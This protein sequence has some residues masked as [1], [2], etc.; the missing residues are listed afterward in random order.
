MLLDKLIF[1]AAHY[2]ALAFFVLTCWGFGRVALSGTLRAHPIDA[3]MGHALSTTIGMGIWICAL[4][5]LGILGAMRA[6]WIF[7]LLAA[8]GILAAA[9]ILA[10][11]RAL[12]L[13]TLPSWRALAF[14]RG[15]AGA[16]VVLV[17]CFVLFSPLKPPHEW[18]ELAY[19]LPHAQQWAQSGKLQVNEWLRYPWFPF[20]Y[21]LLYAA[22]LVVYDDM[23]PHM[24]HA[25]AGWIVALM[26]FRLGMRYTSPFEACLASIIWLRMSRA[27]FS[28]AYIDMGVTLF[29]LGACIAIQLWLEHP[30]ERRWL[31]AAAFMM[32]LAVGSKYQALTFLPLFGV[33]VLW[34]DRRASTIAMATV[35][36]AIPCIYWYVRNALL[37]GDPFNPLG[38]KIFGFTDW[39]LADYE[40]QF[41]DIRRVY[42]WPNGIFWVA[43]LAPL[44]PSL[45]K[46]K[47]LP[48]A[49]I[50]CS[51]AT[52]VW[53]VT[54]HYP[55]Y[56]MPAY[57]LLALLAACVWWR[58][59]QTA[60]Q[61]IGGGTW[62]RL[63][64]DVRNRVQGIGWALVLSG[65]ALAC[66]LGLSRKW[67]DVSATPEARQAYLQKNA[68]STYGDLLEY[69]RLNPMGKIYQS[70]LEGALYY[71]PQPIWGDAFGPWRS[72]D[73]MHLEPDALAAKLTSMNFDALVLHTP[74]YPNL[75]SH[76]HFK[77]Y[78]VEVHNTT[79]YK[80]FRIAG[81]P[82]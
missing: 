68:L 69:L 58:P 53:A 28:N 37:T 13:F 6:Q 9:Q 17:A 40:Y 59:L 52:L 72:R 19:H 49:M 36:L 54:S 82:Q 77:Q 60:L 67:S 23:F 38:G 74:S 41:A 26:V 73:F 3:W 76:Q 22:S 57:P 51:Y 81:H 34:R 29:V 14:S 27:D 78:F 35:F 66:V 30:Q 80:V 62:H 50:F 18:D 33:V 1:V 39:N 63:A 16:A 5:L 70:G 71:A 7:S 45:R 42:G 11:P 24:L 47:G 44:L 48:A 2:G 15:G 12:P 20:N 4:Q 31:A 61:F 8:G 46:A 55:R 56:L 32:G 10:R 25:L 64:P 65:L 79:N 43:A 75:L 21:D